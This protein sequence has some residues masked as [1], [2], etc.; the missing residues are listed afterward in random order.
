MFMNLLVQL[1][2]SRVARTWELHDHGWVKINTDG[3]SRGNPG[4]ILIGFVLRDEEGDV[5]YARGKEIQETTNIEVEASAILEALRYY[6]HHGYSNILVQTDSML[7]KNVIEG[8]WDPPW[9]V[10]A[11]L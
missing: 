10:T 4:R 2:G 11:Y 6:V 8:T 3:A 9:A 5:R 7:M 1:S